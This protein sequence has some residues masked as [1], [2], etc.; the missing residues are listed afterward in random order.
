MTHQSAASHTRPLLGE[1]IP[2]LKGFSDLDTTFLLF[3]TDEFSA[4]SSRKKFKRVNAALLQRIQ[5]EEPPCFLLKAVLEFIGRVNE[6]KILAEPYSITLFELWLNQFSRLTSE[7]ILLVRG[8]IVGRHIPRDEYQ[9]FFPV[10]MGKV[11]QGSHFV[12]AHLSPDIDTTVSS[13]WGWVD[14]FGCRV[15]EGTHQWSFPPGLSDGHIQLYFRRMFGDRVFEQASRPLPTVT[16]SAQDLLT[17]REF[18]KISDAERADSIDH[19]RSE[20]AFVIVDAEGLYRGEWR[21]G[22]AEDVRQ[23]VVGLSNCLRWFE[24]QCHAGMIRVLATQ[25]STI[26]EVAASYEQVLDTTIQD[27]PAAKESSPH[28]QK[29]FHEYLKKVIGLPNGSSHSFRDLFPRLDAV[30]SSSFHRFM[31]RTRELNSPDLFDDLGMLKSDRVMSARAVAN[32]VEAMRQALHTARDGMERLSHLLTVKRDVLGFPPTFV[33]LKSDVDEMRSKIGHFDHLTVVIPER[34]GHWYPLGIVYAND[35][36]KNVLGTASLRDFSTLEETKM[37]SYVEVIS[38]VDHHKMRLQTTTPPTLLIGD[39]QSSNT[40]VAEQ[41]LILNKRY[42]KQD[43]LHSLL[44][45]VEKQALPR[46]DLSEQL[47]KACCRQVSEE[48]SSFFVDPA[49]EMCEYFS[50]IFGILDD[51]DLLSKVSRRDVVCLKNILDRMRS[52]IDGVSSEAVSFDRIPDDDQF[53]PSAAKALL[54]SDDLYSI[55]ASVYQFREK[56]VEKALTAAIEGKPSKLFLDTKEQNGCCRVGQAK[57]FHDN[58]KTYQ[59]HRQALVSL[60]QKGAEEIFSARQQMDFFMQMVSTVPSEKEVYQGVEGNYE[61]QDEMWIWTPEGGVPEQ[62]LIGFLNSF[63]GSPVAQ[64]V[65]ID[66]EIVGPLAELKKTVIDQNFSR[67]HSVIAH[68]TSEG[69]TM[70]FF[71]YKARAINSRKSQVTPFLPKLLP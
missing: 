60:W 34:N 46:K 39:V 35:L 59:S 10:G 50:S 66:V 65:A 22:D 21:S 42:G 54:Q 56:E 6:E 43:S 55:Y 40:L 24:G 2:P 44:A 51:T 57:L 14:A 58:I 11:F 18:H 26:D 15:A 9:V 33:T 25:Q 29:L 31:E 30:F 70:I 19:S 37:A 5:Q 67:A 69:P 38:I 1:A 32:V 64:K 53:V 63:E 36:R 45:M 28:G 62:H 61:H 48:P 52:L 23:V 68:P 13:F 27:C 8:K 7:D 71:R 41:S 47:L 4:L 20:R 12:A 16:I 49:R 3:H 17:K